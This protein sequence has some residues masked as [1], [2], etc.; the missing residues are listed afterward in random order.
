MY[1]CLHFLKL[2]EKPP[3]TIYNVVHDLYNMEYCFLSVWDQSC[4]NINFSII[5]IE[6]KILKP[7]FEVNN[8]ISF[9]NSFLKVVE[10]QN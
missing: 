8:K 5:R 2:I 7:N 4:I 6:Q 10:I 1:Q 9:S 3:E